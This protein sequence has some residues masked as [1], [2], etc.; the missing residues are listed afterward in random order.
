M[1]PSSIILNAS[2]A[3]T[4]VAAVHLVLPTATLAFVPTSSP[5]FHAHNTAH[6]IR[7]RRIRSSSH[8]Q[9]RRLTSSPRTTNHYISSTPETNDNE[10]VDGEVVTASA[11]NIGEPTSSRQVLE[12][13]KK[14]QVAKAALHKLLD[15]QQREVQQ[16]LELL[17]NLELNYDNFE[18][19]QWIE[20]YN[21]WE[22][23]PNN[24]DVD[25]KAL[26]VVDGEGGFRRVSNIPSSSSSPVI[27]NRGIMPTSSSSSSL[28]PPSIS[29]SITASVAVGVDYGYISRSEGC[30]F[31]IINHRGGR[32]E[33]DARFMNYGPP[34]NILELGTQQFMRNL[35]AMIGEYSED[36][37]NSKEDSA[38][39]EQQQYLQSQLQ[40][41]TLDT[42]KIWER[43]HLRGPMVAPYIIKV[44]YYALCYFLDLV[45]E[46]KPP[47]GRFFMLETVARMPY[48]SYITMLH[49]YE[50]LGF[51]RRS[52]DIKRIHFAEEW[53]EVRVYIP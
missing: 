27:G 46:G 49:L 40:E 35:L 2:A 48:F 21:S 14:K 20:G 6:H 24:D 17:H 11:W 25:E 5:S 8:W 52:A 7:C 19:R 44:P 16:T 53:N 1:K 29:S 36:E 9:Q 34:G 4:T 31:E 43:E 39:T 47:F 33:E 37:A 15:R 3:A 23:E 32:E 45:F 41:L 13:S 12:A 28:I 10:G 50:T 38:L 42:K 26:V 22:G 18:K 51:W 30:R